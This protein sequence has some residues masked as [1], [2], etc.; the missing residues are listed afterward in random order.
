MKTHD[1]VNFCSFILLLFIAAFFSGCSKDDDVVQVTD[2]DGN[3][4]EAV[5]IGS[6]VWLK[7]NLK[8]THY[9]NGDAI[10]VRDRIHWDPS[11]TEGVFTDYDDSPSNGVHY[12]HL[13]N[14]Y[15]VIDPRGL[16]PEGYHVA[17][18]D[19][20]NELGDF[21]GGDTIAGGKLKEQG[22][23]HWMSPNEGATNETNFTGLPG[24]ERVVSLTYDD[25]LGLYAS[26]WTSSNSILYPNLAS[27]RS[28]AFDNKELYGRGD[29]AA[30]SGGFSVRCVKD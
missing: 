24:G 19:D 22:L 6:Q 7:S 8:V 16:A 4:Y 13:Y 27:F 23:S 25:G 1:V 15:A 20:W 14:W 26:F 2:F 30:K 12:G 10:I 29:G 5:T 28:L 9:R 18:D 11:S 17:T 3:T 21:L